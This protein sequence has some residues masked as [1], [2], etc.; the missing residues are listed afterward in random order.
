LL[1]RQ[2]DIGRIPF[3]RCGSDHGFTL[4]GA[5]I[6]Y[7]SSGTSRSK[8]IMLSGVRDA[9][10]GICRVAIAFTLNPSVP[11]EFSVSSIFFFIEISPAVKTPHFFHADDF[12]FLHLFCAIFR[13]ILRVFFLALFTG[14]WNNYCNTEQTIRTEFFTGNSQVPYI[15]LLVFPAAATV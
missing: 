2:E 4:V 13:C 11:Y 10:P 15:T 7:S 1:T 3:G 12:E 14:V 8:I 6:H 5:S 9:K